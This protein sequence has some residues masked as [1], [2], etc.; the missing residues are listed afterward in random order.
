MRSPLLFHRHTTACRN[1]LWVWVPAILM[2]DSALKL[3]GA[4]KKAKLVADDSVPSG[5]GSYKFIAATLVLY[6]VLVP[7]ALAT[8]KPAA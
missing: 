3:T 6:A 7:Y 4:A 8:A 1:A 5:S 2:F